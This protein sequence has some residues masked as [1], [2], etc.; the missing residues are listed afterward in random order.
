[1]TKDEK[2]KALEKRIAELE[3][4]VLRLRNNTTVTPLLG[5]DPPPIMWSTTC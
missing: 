1:M 2:I 3:A 4:E 5:I